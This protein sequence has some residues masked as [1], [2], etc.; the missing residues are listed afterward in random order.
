MSC[1]RR[2]CVAINFPVIM[3]FACPLGNAPDF[4]LAGGSS[5]KKVQGARC[6][7]Q[8]RP[9]DYIEVSEGGK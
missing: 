8:L 9:L 4:A 2:D 5:R 6:K 3:Y 7:I 1:R